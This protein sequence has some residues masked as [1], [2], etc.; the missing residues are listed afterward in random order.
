MKL[1]IITIVYNGMPFLPMQLNCFN[2]LKLDWE[3]LVIEGPAANVNC[4]SW[5]KP[6]PPGHSNDGTHEFLMSLTGHPRVFYSWRLMWDGG[7]VEMCNRALAVITEPCFLMQIDSDELYQHWQIERLIAMFSQKAFK[8]ACVRMRY[9]IGP[10]IIAVGEN[11]YGNNRGEWLR[12]WKFEPGQ[13]FVKHE[14]PILSGHEHELEMS[15]YETA[16]YGVIPDHWAYYF[17]KQV[18]YKE[19]FYGY[20]DATKS[21]LK[22]QN[23]PG[24]WPVKLSDFLYWV[25][26]RAQADLLHKPS[27]KP[28]HCPGDGQP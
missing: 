11:C 19:S 8:S 26:D 5:C 17:E 27:H 23:H 2:Q 14:P 9:F 24:P 7:K 13:R 28:T 18:A 25:D 3:W 6:Q 10:N 1:K 16:A 22:L 20:K 12:L 21:W 4:T 15:R